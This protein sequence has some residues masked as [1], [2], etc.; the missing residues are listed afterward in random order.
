MTDPH[1]GR[2]VYKLTAWAEV[3]KGTRL[4][5]G[6]KALLSAGTDEEGMRIQETRRN[7]I[8]LARQFLQC[9]FPQSRSSPPFPHHNLSLTLNRT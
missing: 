7:D 8:I 5:L 9:N 1:I 4:P 6:L 3:L 2:L